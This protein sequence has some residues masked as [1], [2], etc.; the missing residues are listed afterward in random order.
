MGLEIKA[1]KGSVLQVLT[2]IV[3]IFSLF[4]V[5][6]YSISIL[7]D[8]VFWSMDVDC[9]VSRG[10]IYFLTLVLVKLLLAS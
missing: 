6:P 2:L 3:N 1:V 9:G 4:F 10:I 8:E 5:L 7:G